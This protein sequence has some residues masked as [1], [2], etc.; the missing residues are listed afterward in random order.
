MKNDS[1]HTELKRRQ[2]A[3]R[4]SWGEGLNLR[5]HRALSWLNRA[6]MCDDE[7][8]RF[9]FLWV[10]YNAAYAQTL[11]GLEQVTEHDKSNRFIEKLIALDSEKKLYQIVW[12]EFSSSVRVL[13]ANPYV[14]APFWEFQR[15]DKTEAEWKAAFTQAN[16][17]ATAALGRGET[18][19]VLSIILSRLYMLRNQLVHGGATWD[20]E[21]NRDQLRD[22]TKFLGVFVPC[23][24]EVM[25]NNPNAL[26]GEA[27]FPVVHPQ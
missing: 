8:A 4:G 21:I 5:V 9:L 27:V 3:E 11:Q 1:P 22:G 16:N 18:G 15:G 25:M 2:R 24:F 17:A 12:S 6:E 23:V 26:W 7:D 14:F 19:T 10:A 13:L 20:S